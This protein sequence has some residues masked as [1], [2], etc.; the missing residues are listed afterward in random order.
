MDW[1]QV[2]YVLTH[3]NDYFWQYQPWSWLALALL[4][5]Y[6]YRWAVWAWLYF[7]ALNPF[8]G[9]AT[10]VIRVADGDTII[11]GN[12]RRKGRR[13]RYKVRLIGVD[14]PESRRSLYQDVMPFGQE[15][16]DYT[17]KRL[18]KGKRVFL[19]YDEEKRDKFGRLLAYVYLPNGEFFNKTLVRKG[20]AFAKYYSP[21]GKHRRVFEKLARKAQ[22]RRRGLWRI[23]NADGE[24]SRDYKRS[25]HYREFIES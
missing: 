23:Y 11:V 15:A 2:Y 17:K 24:L 13:S 19:Y 12:P 16:S 10:R 1:N 3:L 8:R 4:L 20:Y 7:T 6:A 22:R 5:F 21:N 14:T 9:W 25:R 18:P